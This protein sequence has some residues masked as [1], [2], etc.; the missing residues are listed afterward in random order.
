VLTI[1][2]NPA[3]L[4]V[5]AVPVQAGD[6][7]GAVSFLVKTAATGTSTHSWAAIYNG[8]TAGAAL[9]G[10]Q[11]P[12]VTGGFALGANTL[13]LGSAAANTGSV[14]TAQGP[15]TPA[16]VPQGP[17]VWGVALYNS[18][19]TNGP[20]IDGML[21]GSVAGEVGHTSQVPLASYA[22]LAATATA[23]SVL[24]AMTVG[25]PSGASGI[26]YIVLSRA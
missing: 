7:F 8:V 13:L 17:A 18:S 5:F 15:S 4:Y 24:P 14:G 19:G 21:A 20:V 16:N 2:A 10:A 6:I 22:A 23:P 11:T 12:D 26:P 3:N 9:V 25:L 1:G